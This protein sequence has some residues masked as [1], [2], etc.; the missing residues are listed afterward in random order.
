MIKWAGTTYSLHP[1][2]VIMLTLSAITG[3]IMELLTLFSIVLIHELGHVVA[4]RW[5]GWSIDEVKLLP[6]GGV[7]ETKDG[8]VSPAWQE[9][10]VAIAG[11]LQ[12]GI[13]IVVAYVCLWTGLWS[14]E[15]SQYFVEANVMIASFNLLPI[16]P[17]DGGRIVQAISSR[18]LSYHHALIAGAWMSIGASILLIG[19]ALQPLLENKP[20]DLNMLTLAV[21]LLWSNGTELRHVPY[22]F[23]RF[24]MNR[25]QR[26]RK[27]EESGTL[28]VPIV[29]QAGR[30]LIEVLKRFQRDGYHLIYIMSA[31][32]KVRKVIPEQQLID[33]Y[34]KD[35]SNWD[36]SVPPALSG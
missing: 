12:N 7:A 4:A 27:R 31:E 6:F 16:L 25:P 2:F 9:I 23:V 18:W 26:L 5:C 32:G 11:P 3:H 34:F 1:L 22:R 35:K 19:Y 10:V 33:A 28:G 8:A 36:Q 17:L 30:P 29:V 13:L 21:F 24:L 15:W 14:D 20:F